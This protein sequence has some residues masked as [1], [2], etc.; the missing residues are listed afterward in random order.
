MIDWPPEIVASIARRRSVIVIGSGVSANAKNDAGHRPPTWGAFLLQALN[1]LG[2]RRTHITKAL[3]Q[4]RYLE[5]CD[6]LKEAYGPAWPGYLKKVFVEPQFKSA[7]IHKRILGLDSRI[8]VS[9]NFDRIYDNYAIGTTENTVSVK[10]YYD[11]DI[12]EAIAGSDRYILKPHGS[13]DSAS[14][15]IFTLDE[16][17][18]ARTQY[19][20]FYEVLNALLHTHTFLCIGCGLADPDMQ[21]IFEDYKYKFRECPHFMTLPRPVP[22]ATLNLIQRTRGITVIPYSSAANHKE[23]VDSLAELGNIVSD[24]RDSIAAEQ[25]W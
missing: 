20:N 25:S 13:I 6:Y 10:N 4:F 24:A 16:Y 11:D 2:G 17:G 22:A 5:A 15:I 8:V 23:L 1:D 9:L 3:K 14:K 21:L 7:E 18:R 19:A 12:R